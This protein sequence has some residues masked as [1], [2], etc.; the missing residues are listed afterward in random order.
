V[1]RP[2][3][4]KLKTRKDIT[5]DPTEIQRI[6]RGYFENRV[7]EIVARAVRQ[8]KE[9]KRIQIEKTEVKFFCMFR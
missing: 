3:L 8:D 1:R 9:I 7:F 5:T 2:K 6:M 4:I